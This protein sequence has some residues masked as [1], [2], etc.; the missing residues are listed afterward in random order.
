[1]GMGDVK[2]AFASGLVL[3][4]PD[5]ALATIVSFILGGL[6]GMFLLVSGKKHVKD[7][8]PFAPFF[9]V[10]VFITIFLGHGMM[11][12]YFGLFGI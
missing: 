5:I 11:G 8:L 9:A 12:G 10:G 4:W 6:V 1:M 7:K 3:G 2:L